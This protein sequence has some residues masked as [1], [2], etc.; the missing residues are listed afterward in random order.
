[1]PAPIDH[2]A[3]G[4]N[5][6]PDQEWEQVVDNPVHQDRR[7]QAVERGSGEQRDQHR[8]EYAEAAR[9]IAGHPGEN[10]P[11]HVDA[12]K[13][14]VVQFDAR[15]QQYVECRRG[16]AQIDAGDRNLRQR[17]RKRRQ[18]KVAAAQ[19][20]RSSLQ[21]RQQQV[22]RRSAPAAGYRARG[23][24]RDRGAAPA[25]PLVSPATATPPRRLPAP[26]AKVI[27]TIAMTPA[28]SSV[29]SPAGA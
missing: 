18:D 20:D 14:E 7:H 29:D 9:H 28:I 19:A 23:P 6:Q 26:S 22:G 11:S 13:A 24:A 16:K 8:F 15:R 1:M 21:P 4:Q 3:R 2:F 25:Q 12:E 27:D 10:R 17:Y 5:T